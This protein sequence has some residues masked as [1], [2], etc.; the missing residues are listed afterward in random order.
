[1][2]RTRKKPYTGAKRF[3]STCRCHGGCSFCEGNRKHSSMKRL[4][5][6]SLKKLRSAELEEYEEEKYEEEF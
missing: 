5:V 6:D 4:K 2:S 3:D 1:M